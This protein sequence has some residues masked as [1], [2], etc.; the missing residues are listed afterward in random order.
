MQQ[1]EQRGV[2]HE[3]KFS[4]PQT[5]IMYADGSREDRDNI[6]QFSC[7]FRDVEVG[8]VNLKNIARVL[9]FV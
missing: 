3:I 7:A 6:F 5:T 1:F 2:F 9:L 4:R 8:S